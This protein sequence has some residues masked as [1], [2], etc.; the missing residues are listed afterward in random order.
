IGERIGA[1]GGALRIA[2]AAPNDASA[3]RA[4]AAIGSNFD[5]VHLS[6]PMSELE[7]QDYIEQ[8]LAIAR[9]PASIRAHFDPRT[10]RTLHRISAGI[11]R[12]VNAAAAELLQQA[13]DVSVE[14]AQPTAPIDHSAI[15]ER[16]ATA[17]AA[18]SADPAAAGD[19][20]AS[21]RIAAPA[22]LAAAGEAAA[23]P[24]EE[25]RVARR[26]AEPVGVAVRVGLGSAPL[27]KGRRREDA[28]EPSAEGGEPSDGSSLDL[29]AAEQDAPES[30]PDLEV[31]APFAS[32][33]H[34]IPAAAPL[35]VEPPPS[36]RRVALTLLFVAGATVA[37]PLI[38]SILD[39]R[40]P[41]PRSER[42]RAQSAEE[43]PSTGERPQAASE[44]IARPVEAA[45]GSMGSGAEQPRGA[46]EPR[47]AEPHRAASAGEGVG[48]FPVSINATPWANIEVDGVDLG[49]T[50]LA[51][52][53]LVAGE[54]VFRARMPDGRVI[55][56]TLAI[57]AAQRFISFE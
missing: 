2:L 26:R 54:H 50:P 45:R 12:R 4:L 51:N 24:P 40:A 3:N 23:S 48:P 13:P 49:A 53:P 17:R 25:R 42:A 19:V 31:A 21:P 52:V 30:N 15:S 55:E 44:A 18:A 56:R 16:A 10:I 41:D 37:I 38:R 22:S 9:A 7:T 20:A 29:E 11:P 34:G 46:A 47:V 57:D 8:R 6:E 28:I 32:A 1:A 5:V 14:A 43:P 35:R 39:E 33:P 36:R 27:S